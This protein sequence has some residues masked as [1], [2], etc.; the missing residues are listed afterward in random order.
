MRPRSQDETRNPNP[1]IGRG[2]SE[3]QRS[4][5][6]PTL[7]CRWLDWGFTNPMKLE[8]QDQDRT[9]ITANELGFVVIEQISILQ[10]SD[11]VFIAP[12]HIDELC[13][14]LQSVKEQATKNRAKYLREK[15]DR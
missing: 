7:T 13:R 2:F 10:E 6:V 1:A 3:A 8:I 14:M 11:E 12:S 15:E 4:G 9:I 5:P